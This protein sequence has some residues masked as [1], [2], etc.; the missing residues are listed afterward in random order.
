MKKKLP[1]IIGL[2]AVIAFSIFYGFTDKSHKI[3]DNNVNTA[4]YTDLG[5]LPDGQE[6]NQAFTS[7]EDVLDG[8]LIKCNPAGDYANSVVN[9]EVLDGDTREV[10]AKVSEPGTNIAPRKLHLF[11]LDTPLTDCKGK[12]YILKITETGSTVGNGI[13]LY[14]QPH[15]EMTSGFT[16]NNDAVPGC[17]VMKTITTRFDAETFI[18]MFLSIMFIWGFM[19]FLY[20]LFK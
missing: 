7:E 2:I 13:D 19:Y 11:R 14:Y 10:L 15:P 5:A 8:F 3:Y 1:M 18:I 16:S 6:L 9:I 12:D 20:R 4:Q 17:L